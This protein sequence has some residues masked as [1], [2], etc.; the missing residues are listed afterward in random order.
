MRD[1]QRSTVQPTSVERPQKW[2]LLTRAH[3]AQRLTPCETDRA[4]NLCKRSHSA[5]GRCI[6]DT[7]G[8][9]SSCLPPRRTWTAP[10]RLPAPCPTDR[11][12]VR[13][14]SAARRSSGARGS[15]F[16]I[17]TAGLVTP[18]RV[19]RSMAR[20]LAVLRKQRPPTQRRPEVGHHRADMERPV[21]V[22][23]SGACTARRPG[24]R[25]SERDDRSVTLS[26]AEVAYR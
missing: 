9:I 5:R 21:K 2:R 1:S 20:S 7:L 6:P 19:A 26:V 11:A 18:S 24:V 3:P 4:Q 16:E 12:L 10:R 25:R 8:E 17:R 22:P 15:T 23:P 13:G 14:R